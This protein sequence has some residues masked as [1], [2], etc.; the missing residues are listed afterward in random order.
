MSHVS[1]VATPYLIPR[2]RF[3]DAT[4][5]A[6]YM[7]GMHSRTLVRWARKGDLPAYPMGEGQRR[8]WRFLE[9]DLDQWMRSRRTG[10][11]ETALTTVSRTLYASHRCSD[12]GSE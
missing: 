7:G 6:E 11:S 2:R 3:L 9:E 5:A 12:Q 1:P 4:E 10:R 8:L